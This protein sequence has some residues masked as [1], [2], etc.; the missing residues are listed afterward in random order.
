MDLDRYV[1]DELAEERALGH[2]SADG[3]RG[4]GDGY[5]G[6]PEVEVAPDAVH[7]E[8]IEVGTGAPQRSVQVFAPI[9]CEPGAPGVIVIHENKGLVPYITNVARR[10]AGDGYV[11]MAPDLLEPL[12]GTDSFATTDEV[13]EALRTRTPDE[14]L[15]DLRTALDGLAAHP[16]VDPSRLAVIGFCFGGG[17]AWRLLAA[18]ERLAAGIPF[19]GPPPSEDEL[20]RISVP[21]LAVYGETDERITATLPATRA[22]MEGRPFEALVLEGAGHAFH[23]DTNPDRYDRDAA[24]RAWSHARSFL[25]RELGTMPA[26]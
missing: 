6:D 9:G 15:A 24:L 10:L 3:Q 18:E 22:A 25:A 21:V 13:T 12:G 14:L 5:P 17:L 11:A 8:R 4:D 1:E 26:A 7:A 20:A 19:Y 16:L 23:N 2:A